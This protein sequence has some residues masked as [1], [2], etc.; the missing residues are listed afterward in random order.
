[1]HLSCSLPQGLLTSFSP[2][3]THLL[4]S[5]EELS[6]LLNI[7]YFVWEKPT[8]VFLPGKYYVQRCLVVYSPWGC[9]SQARLSN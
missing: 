4:C 8:L 1:M 3:I 6:F 5:K 2:S 7:F 9:Y